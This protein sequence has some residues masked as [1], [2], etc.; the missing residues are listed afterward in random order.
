MT[1]S[2]VDWGDA[3]MKEPVYFSKFMFEM[4][5]LRFADRIICN[6]P[7]KELSYQSFKRFPVV[8]ANHV[9]LDQKVLFQHGIYLTDDD[10]KGLLTYIN[11][12]DF[13]PYRHKKASWNDPDF[14]CE[15]D[16]CYKM[17]F[18]AFTDSYLPFLKLQMTLLFW[19]EW[20]TERLLNYIHS[21][22]ISTGRLLCS[23]PVVPKGK[24]KR[25]KAK[26]N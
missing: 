8:R 26:N 3:H 6:I 10:V 9:I 16:E 1:A 7:A 23:E 14:K 22:F 12:W 19:H 18:F 21:T 25:K 2:N 15:L 13:E 5:G 24:K 11:A 4:K 17:N 20:P